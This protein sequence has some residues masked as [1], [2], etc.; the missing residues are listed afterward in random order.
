MCDTNVEIVW[1][2]ALVEEVVLDCADR[3]GL[4]LLLEVSG[5]FDGYAG[6]LVATG[7]SENAVEALFHL[8]EEIQGDVEVVRGYFE[9]VAETEGSDHAELEDLHGLGG[10]PGAHVRGCLGAVVAMVDV[11]CGVAVL[12]VLGHAELASE[13]LEG[14]ALMDDALAEFEFLGAARRERTGLVETALTVLEDGAA[15]ETGLDDA[16]L[17]HVEGGFCGEGAEEDDVR[18][19]DQVAA[20]VFGE[21]AETL[22]CV[23]D[24]V[25]EMNPVFGGLVDEVDELVGDYGAGCDF[26][27]YAMGPESFEGTIE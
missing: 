17:L 1:G 4:V 18:A 9:V 3:E 14:S 19:V 20:L 11:P 7:T 6:E 8:G 26:A 10:E 23:V 25:Q 5:D 13:V 21:V 27:C 15:G 12:G 24:V 22:V 2:F 16:G